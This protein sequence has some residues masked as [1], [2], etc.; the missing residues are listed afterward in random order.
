MSE[1][2]RDR[3]AFR[4]RWLVVAVVVPALLALLA[5]PAS[6]LFGR[7]SFEDADDAAVTLNAIAG[8]PIVIGSLATYGLIVMAVV[9][10]S[11]LDRARWAT[12]PLAVASGTFLAALSVG[13][14]PA[15]TSAVT[16]MALGALGLVLGALGGRAIATASLNDPAPVTTAPAPPGAVRHDVA[17]T[18]TAV[19]MGQAPPLPWISWIS[20]F[21]IV[22][23]QLALTRDSVAW[24]AL[25]VLWGAA[26]PIHLIARSRVRARVVIGPTGVQITSG[27]GRT[28]H[29][30]PRDTIVGASTEDLPWWW[31]YAL[32]RRSTARRLT[33]ATR[34]GPALRIALTD[35]SDVVLA[36]A[37]PT[38]AAGVINSL[39][40]RRAA[41]GATHAP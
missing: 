24:L 12:T 9:R 6:M 2:R 30:V 39:L 8:V 3:S 37:D 1:K 25:V 29:V 40:D 5:A 16:L 7:K 35:G 14:A 34:G 22:A 41:S 26:V 31:G 28:L 19:W 38:E 20:V 11:P 21:A 4:W 15:E 13:L 23:Y 18:A 32:M 33:I 27:L 10:R 17:P 36:V